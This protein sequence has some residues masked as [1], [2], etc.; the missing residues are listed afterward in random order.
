[1]KL[2][3]LIEKRNALLMEMDTMLNK[4]SE[5]TRALTSEELTAYDS[6]K[7]EVENLTAT[8]NAMQDAEKR[9][10][11]NASQS[12][13]AQSGTGSEETDEQKE[14][15]AFDA[16]IRS[17]KIGDELRAGNDTEYADNTVVIPTTIAS[18]IVE[19]VKE[20]SPIYSLATKIT[21]KGTVVV[22]VWG[23]DGSDDIT[24]EYA[25]E[26]TE[27]ATHSGKFTSINLTGYLFS[28]QAKISKTLINN[29]AFDVVAFV[30]K[31]I[32]EAVAAFYDKELIKGTDQKMTGAVS[33]TVGV[34]A[35]SA[36]AITADELITLQMSI[37][38][39]Y[40]KDARWLMH[41]DTL[42]A[43]RKLK[44]GNNNYLLN[45][46]LTTEFGWTLLGKPVMLSENA[47]KMVAGAKA[48]VYG[49]FSGLWL[50][51]AEA[52]TMQVLHELYAKQHKV[53]ISL[54]GE[55][56]SN[57]CEPQ[58]LRTLAMKAAS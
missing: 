56:D 19:T 10:Q 6:K 5:E 36:T 7:S 53:G 30:I 1:M 18:K 28:A 13:G 26:G 22:P 43:L 15:R 34:T 3:A 14:Y 9:A 20:L 51:T 35:A 52:P 57:I 41:R 37:I 27:P 12:N 24:C 55:S 50:K 4:A 2:K 49:D 54:F 32:A 46:D 33:A 23:P 29:T 45:Q 21:A 48:I 39:Q 31:K 8:I 16:L 58:K 17:G 25:T 11:S 40:Q 38:Q 44:D 42:T 47:P